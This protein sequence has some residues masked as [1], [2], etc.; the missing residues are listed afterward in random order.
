MDWKEQLDD[1]GRSFVEFLREDVDQIITCVACSKQIGKKE[2]FDVVEKIYTHTRSIEH[3]FKLFVMN[4][5]NMETID[6]TNCDSHGNDRS[7]K[8]CQ[9]NWSPKPEKDVEIVRNINGTLKISGFNPIKYVI[10]IVHLPFMKTKIYECET[11]RRTV[12]SSLENYFAK[13]SSPSKRKQCKHEPDTS[14]QNISASSVSDQVIVTF[15]FQKM[16]IFK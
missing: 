2:D 15:P 6:L 14:D 7:D 9:E 12:L 10:P 1:E 5:V 8:L 13:E 16:L 4:N 3:G 11:S